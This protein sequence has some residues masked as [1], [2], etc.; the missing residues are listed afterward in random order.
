MRALSC[1]FSLGLLLGCVSLMGP[2][3]AEL[4]LQD[5]FSYADGELLNGKDPAI[6]G[7]WDVQGGAASLDIQGGILDTQGDARFAYIGLDSPL[8][9]GQVLTMILDGATTGGTMFGPNAG[10]AGVSLF[11]NGDEKVFVGSPFNQDFWGIDGGVP[12]LH[13][14]NNA[15]EDNTATFTYEFDSGDWTFSLAAGAPLSGT[16]T[17]GVPLNRVRIANGS[18][19]DLAL[20]AISV[21]ISAVVPEPGSITLV[22]VALA[23]LALVVRSRR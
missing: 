21:D 16:G 7:T 10:W 19:G 22:G 12:G 5:D 20:D 2:A 1:T 15:D 18:N 11:E 14:S 4:V 13:L 6:G 9:P 3:N 8:G 17:A 23:G